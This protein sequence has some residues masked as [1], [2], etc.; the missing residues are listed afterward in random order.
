[1]A[2]K[3][4][5]SHSFTTTLLSTT[6]LR[7]RSDDLIC[8]LALCHVNCRFNQL[9]HVSTAQTPK[10]SSGHTIDVH[11][12]AGFAATEPQI[13]HKTVG[14]STSHLKISERTLGIRM[15][16]MPGGMERVTKIF[17]HADDD[18]LVT[19]PW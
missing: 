6:N 13:F 4:G 19:I 5:S 14:S 15:P 8:C 9:S 18:C 17:D 3:F 12:D 16:D 7:N 2:E 10:W 1:M 11:G